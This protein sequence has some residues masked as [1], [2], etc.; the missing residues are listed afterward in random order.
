MK[1]K[2]G[3][4]PGLLLR[5]ERSKFTAVSGF[6]FY[7]TGR[8]ALEMFGVVLPTLQYLVSTKANRFR[9]GCRRSRDAVACGPSLFRPSIVAK[10]RLNFNDRIFFIHSG[11]VSP[12]AFKQNKAWNIAF[13]PI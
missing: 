10:P 5:I 6:K 7:P 8:A 13:I 2:A 3:V 9:Y 11:N 1:I 4:Q 12:L